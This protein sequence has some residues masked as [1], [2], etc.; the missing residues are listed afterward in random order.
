M[1]QWAMRLPGYVLHVTSMATSPC[2]LE[3]VGG[4]STQVMQAFYFLFISASSA[5]TR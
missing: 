2:Q 3:M 1:Q 5:G 4:P